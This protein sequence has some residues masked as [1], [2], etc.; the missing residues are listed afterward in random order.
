MS[1]KGFWYLWGKTTGAGHEDVVDLSY[2]LP[3]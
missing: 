2:V 3:F 1:L